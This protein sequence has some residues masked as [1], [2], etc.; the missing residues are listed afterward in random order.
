MEGSAKEEKSSYIQDKAA[1]EILQK[2]ID[3]LEV[4]KTEKGGG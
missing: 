1:L 2:D 4:E 3:K